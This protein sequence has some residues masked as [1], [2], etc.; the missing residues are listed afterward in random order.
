MPQALL[1]I[2]EPRRLVLLIINRFVG[3]IVRSHCL[4]RTLS[5]SRSP[6]IVRFHGDQLL[7]PL[8]AA[9]RENPRSSTDRPE[10]LLAVDHTIFIATS[11]LLA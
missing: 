3:A 2:E 10:P 11:S 7:Y 5:V 4:G 9:L 8:L 6:Y 1:L